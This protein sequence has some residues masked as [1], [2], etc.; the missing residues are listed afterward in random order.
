MVF[1]C[2]KTFKYTNNYKQI[3]LGMECLISE[4]FSSKNTHLKKGKDGDMRCLIA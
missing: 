2:N 3:V 4:L 1:Y